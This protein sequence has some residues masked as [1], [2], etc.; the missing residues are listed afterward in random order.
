MILNLKVRHK[1]T[2]QGDFFFKGKVKKWTLKQ[3]NMKLKQI[4]FV[5]LDCFMQKNANS[6]KSVPNGSKP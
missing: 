1:S 5:K 6:Q 2:Q 4:D 3:T